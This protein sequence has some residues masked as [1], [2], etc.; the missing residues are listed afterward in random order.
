MFWL[1]NKKVIFCCALLTKVL[2]VVLDFGLT[3]CLLG[4][5]VC[6]LWPAEFYYFIKI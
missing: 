4:N 5:F 6:V 3:H 1:R 2:K